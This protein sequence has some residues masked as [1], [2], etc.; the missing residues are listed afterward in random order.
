MKPLQTCGGAGGGGGGGGG[1]FIKDWICSIRSKFFPSRVEPHLGREAKTKMMQLSPLKV[2]VHP[3]T[4]RKAWLRGPDGG[5][6]DGVC[7]GG[8]GGGGGGVHLK[9]KSKIAFPIS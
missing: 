4:L 9:D 5:G 8:G 3:F 7:G 2:S 6:D 1:L